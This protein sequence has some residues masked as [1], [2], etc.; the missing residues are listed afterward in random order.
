MYVVRLAIQEKGPKDK[1]RPKTN[2]DTNPKDKPRLK[3]NPDTKPKD[4]PRLKTNPDT[5]QHAST[6]LVP[7]FTCASVRHEW[8]TIEAAWRRRETRTRNY[9]ETGKLSA[10]RKTLPRN[11]NSF[12]TNRKGTREKGAGRRERPKR[13]TQGEYSASEERISGNRYTK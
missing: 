4:K 11:C 5:K 6:A 12:D 10:L 9:E 3:T 1:P 2:P 13:K 8:Q 7:I